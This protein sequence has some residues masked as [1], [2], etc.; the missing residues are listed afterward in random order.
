MCAHTPTP[1]LQKDTVGALD[2]H[3]RSFLP[4]ICPGC[5]V[6]LVE[7]LFP[8]VTAALSL[9]IFSAACLVVLTLSSPCPCVCWSVTGLITNKLST[10]LTD[11]PSDWSTYSESLSRG[12]K[13]EG[14][15]PN[16]APL[17]VLTFFF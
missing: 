9:W 16:P 13:E 2:L 7:A 5:R 3:R 12:H 8:Q 15:N 10:Q 4:R 11:L 14:H 6:A 1:T 17:C